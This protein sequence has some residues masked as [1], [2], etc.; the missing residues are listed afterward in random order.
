MRSINGFNNSSVGSFGQGN[1]SAAGLNKLGTG[2]D[3]AKTSMSNDVNFQVSTG[4]TSYSNPAEAYDYGWVFNQFDVFV[5]KWLNKTNLTAEPEY[6]LRCVNGLT[7][8]RNFKVDENGFITEPEFVWNHRLNKWNVY[9]T[10]SYVDDP[11]GNADIFIDGSYIKLTKNKNYKVFLYKISPTVDALQESKSPQIAIIEEGS[12]ADTN[13]KSKFSG[14]GVMQTYIVSSPTEHNIIASDEA[15]KIGGF[16]GFQLN[17]SLEDF[18]AQW[19]SIIRATTPPGDGVLHPDQYPQGS[20]SLSEYLGTGKIPSFLFKS[21]NPY[22]GLTADGNT[23]DGV[24]CGENWSKGTAGG[25][26]YVMMN[27]TLSGYG[28]YFNDTDSFNYWA[29]DVLVGIDT[30]AY[31]YTPD[32]KL[33]VMT[34]LINVADFE[35]TNPEYLGNPV[36]FNPDALISVFSSNTTSLTTLSLEVPTGKPVG[37]VGFKYFDCA[38][39]EIAYIKWTPLKPEE[40]TGKGRFYIYQINNGPIVFQDEPL[41]IDSKIVATQADAHWG[42]DNDQYVSPLITEIYYWGDY[43]ADYTTGKHRDNSTQIGG[44]LPSIPTRTSG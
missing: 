25:G 27:D 30:S 26:D 41:L 35:I 13:V 24:P 18:K 37:N 34:G 31:L 1:S 15:G 42:E 39:K 21:T 6:R 16:Q 23:I 9:P 8:F 17:E 32:D 2:I 11:K 7:T 22:Q 5:E 43:E 33:N 4:G 3:M 20:G 19:L 44:Y 29:R 36:S 14:G 10:G 12:E 38:R 40:P 28:R